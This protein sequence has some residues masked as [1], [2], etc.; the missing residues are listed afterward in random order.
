MS[1]HQHQPPTTTVLVD[2]DPVAPPTFIRNLGNY[3]DSDVSM[4]TQV[5]QTVAGCFVLLCQLRSIRHLVL[6]QIFQSLV[7]LLALTRL[8]Y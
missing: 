7:V 3:V 6:G 5:M 4:K 8:D 1:R 2:V